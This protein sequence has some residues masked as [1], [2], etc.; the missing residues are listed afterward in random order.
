MCA[1]PAELNQVLKFKRGP[2][3]SLIV[4]KANSFAMA[5]EGYHWSNVRRLCHI[6]IGGNSGFLF[7]DKRY[8]VGASY[9][10]S[11]YVLFLNSIALLYG[12]AESPSISVGRHQ[13]ALSRRLLSGEA[14]AKVTVPWDIGIS[15]SQAVNW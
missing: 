6:E 12:K 10:A 3:L 9:D 1:M 13:P 7:L 11:T 14:W 5:I 15:N 2:D 8:I 4:Q